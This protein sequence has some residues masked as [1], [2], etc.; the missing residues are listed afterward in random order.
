MTEVRYLFSEKTLVGFHIS[1]HATS[2]ADDEQ[3]RL[4]CAFISSAAYLTAN[5]I[6]EIIGAKAIAEDSSKNGEMFFKVK[7]D[8]DKAL[9]VLLGFKLH[10]EQ[11][12]E[13]YTEYIKIISEV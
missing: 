7:S 13:Q 5:T 11:L 2:S 9:P 6:T 4:V 1:G 10:M 3:G 8:I 12:S